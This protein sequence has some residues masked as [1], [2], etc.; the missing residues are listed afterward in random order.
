MHFRTQEG[1]ELKVD[2]VLEKG[3]RILGIEVKLTSTTGT[4]CL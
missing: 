2:F 3:N 4:I 1:K